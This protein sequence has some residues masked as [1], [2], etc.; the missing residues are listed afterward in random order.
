MQM[1][2]ECRLRAATHDPSVGGHFDVA[3]SVGSVGPCDR[4]A[5]LSA[6]AAKMMTDIVRQQCHGP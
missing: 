4:S 6:S 1:H 5:D 3:L 2:Y